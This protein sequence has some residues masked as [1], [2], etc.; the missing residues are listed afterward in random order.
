ML[1][2]RTQYGFSC[3]VVLQQQRAQRGLQKPFVKVSTA[4][5]VL[6]EAVHH[7]TCLLQHLLWIHRPRRI[8]LEPHFVDIPEGKEGR[9]AK[10][11]W[12]IS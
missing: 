9:E 8:P 12:P 4:V 6:Q 10:I 5:K 11:L 7:V 3:S 2:T 1:I